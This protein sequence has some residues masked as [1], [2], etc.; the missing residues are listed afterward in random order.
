M[1]SLGIAKE[2]KGPRDII[3]IEM[4]SMD[5]AHKGCLHVA[6]PF[7]RQKNLTHRKRSTTMF[8]VSRGH[9]LSTY[10]HAC[11]IRAS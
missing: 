9:V 6:W 1:C 4:G 11:G 5:D 10:L 7:I 2:L 8:M 3:W